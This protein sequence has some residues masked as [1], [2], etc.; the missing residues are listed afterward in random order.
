MQPSSQRIIIPRSR[1]GVENLM[2][3]KTANETES[4]RRKINQEA[5]SDLTVLEDNMSKT[6]SDTDNE[7]SW[8]V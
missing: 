6:A 5:F 3:C 7:M 4:V 1:K 8:L 2:A